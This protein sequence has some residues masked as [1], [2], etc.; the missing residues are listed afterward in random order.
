MTHYTDVKPLAKR[1]NG[2]RAKS[3]DVPIHRPDCAIDDWPR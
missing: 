2:V 1:I 3:D